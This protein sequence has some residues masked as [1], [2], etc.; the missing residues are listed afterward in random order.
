MLY[1]GTWL[2]ALFFG[3]LTAVLLSVIASGIKESEVLV[4]SLYTGGCALGFVGTLPTFLHSYRW[5]PLICVG[6]ALAAI[7]GYAFEP[8][9]QAGEGETA[10]LF[11]IGLPTLIGLVVGGGFVRSTQRRAK[12]RVP[13]ARVS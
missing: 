8:E 7:G 11:L 2:A 5:A 9:F 4:V 10:A 13:A 12:Q 6:A 3:L 1:V